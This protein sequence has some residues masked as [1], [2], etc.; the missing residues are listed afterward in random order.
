M[1]KLERWFLS[2]M[3]ALLA[4]GV[5]L[6]VAQAQTPQPPAPGNKMTGDS[7]VNCHKGINDAWQSGSH[8]RAGSDPIFAEAWNAQGK[9]GAC[10]VCHTT[11]YDPATGLSEA[12][13]VTCTACHSPIP[14]NHPAD[15]NADRCVSRSVRQMP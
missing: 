4:A 6:V 14:A 10:L 2:L 15:S 13:D 1:T 9:P 8:G 3:F 5:T 12:N 7:C 11:G